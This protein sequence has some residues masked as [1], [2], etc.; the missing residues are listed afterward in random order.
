[1]ADDLM[2]ALDASCGKCGGVHE[3]TFCAAW[4]EYLCV[5]CR[6]LRNNDEL[7]V[8]L[9]IKEAIA[10]TVRDITAAA[11]MVQGMEDRSEGGGPDG[12]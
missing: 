2:E 5:N 12:A 4:A 6:A 11:R 3:V 9:V 10:A 7:R 8:P 1:V